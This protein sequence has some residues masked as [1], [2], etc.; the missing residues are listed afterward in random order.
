MSEKTIDRGSKPITIRKR[1]HDELE[2]AAV[3]E[4][5]TVKVAKT[6]KT[7][8]TSTPPPLEYE[9]TLSIASTAPPRYDH[10]H[11]HPQFEVSMASM[12]SIRSHLSELTAKNEAIKA[13]MQEMREGVV[14]E[15]LSHMRV[16]SIAIGQI[17]RADL[18]QEMR[19]LCLVVLE[20]KKDYM[21]QKEKELLHLE[22]L[23]GGYDSMLALVD[24]ACVEL[25]MT[26]ESRMEF[27]QL[28]TDWGP[29]KACML[30]VLY[31]C[32]SANS[33]VALPHMTRLAEFTNS[34]EEHQRILQ[35]LSNGT[36]SQVENATRPQGAFIHFSKLP[37]EIRFQIWQESFPKP[38]ILTSNAH[39]NQNLVLLS[40]CH[41]A[42]VVVESHYSRVFSPTAAFPRGTISFLHTNLNTDTIIRDLT[43]RDVPPYTLFSL[44]NTN[45]TTTCHHLLSGLSQIKHLAL[46]YD[47]LHEN[48]GTLFRSVQ[49]CCP[50][51]KT[52]TIFPA[53]QLRSSKRYSNQNL[54]FIDVDSNLIDYTCF[55][56]DNLPDRKIRHKAMRGL[57]VVIMLFSHSLQYR[58]VFKEYVE[59]YGMGWNPIIKVCLLA[60]WNRKMR[61]W[62]MRT[63]AGLGDRCSRG[64][65]GQDGRTYKGFMEAEMVCGEDGEAFSRYDGVRRLFGEEE[66]ESFC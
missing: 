49:V 44:T 33:F 65:E 31:L 42:R 59:S 57:G 53:E 41:E 22:R 10:P 24:A 47:I 39:H 11:D 23:L 27:L 58:S 66:G 25:E 29:L 37:T 55:R 46:A 54:K 8:E 13:T 63:L 2:P 35:R 56:L 45:F 7:P 43:I 12:R 60:R 30:I 32:K 14:N 26:I 64:F 4:S 36:S 19:D 9:A 16:R 20:N 38:R 6:T 50:Q 61:G 18:E 62:Q 3:E 5:R 28:G 48:G 34:Y 40:T 21:C 52:L 51:L 17:G 15:L 1:K